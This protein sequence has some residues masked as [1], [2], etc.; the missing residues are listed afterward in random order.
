[1]FRILRD[2]VKLGVLVNAAPVRVWNT[3]LDLIG[4][5]ADS[6]TS[7]CYGLRKLRPWE[8]IP[9]ASHSSLTP[10]KR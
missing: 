6:L 7:K 10:L 3:R 4:L 8:R 5:G 9:R 1:M 2:L